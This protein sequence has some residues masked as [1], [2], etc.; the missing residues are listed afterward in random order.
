MDTLK[1]QIP[2][3]SHRKKHIIEN[4]LFMSEL[5][6]KNCFIVKQ[7]FNV[8][9]EY[10]LNLYEGDSLTLNT[11]D[12]F[13]FDH[14]TITIGN[15]PYN[16]E[17][18]SAGSAKPLYNKFIERFID[19]CDILCFVIPSRWFSCGKGLDTFREGMLKRTDIVY[20]KHF[21]DASK[22]FGNSVDIKGGVNYF[23]KDNFYS[24]ECNFNGTMTKLNKY[25]VFVD[26]MYHSIIDKIIPFES[27]TTLFLGNYFGIITNDKKLKNT[28]TKDTVKCYVSQ[29]KG[30]ERY[31]SN[32]D[33]KKEYNFWKVITTE[34]AH[35]HKSGFGNTFI[36]NCNEIYSGSYIS[37]RVSSESEAGSL[38]SYLKCR[39]PNFMLSLRKN[40]QHINTSTCTWIPLVPLDK[41]WTDTEVYSY[42]KLSDADIQLINNTDIIG[43]RTD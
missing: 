29:Q 39:L 6:K 36:G 15:P 42:L 30:F 25:D 27:I 26:G 35:K 9:N 7:I 3:D 5:N 11:L 20:M 1:V 14:N 38:L 37:F 2:D 19:K 18:K 12:V 16:E 43:Y 41:I 13:G 24:G 32:S 33:I 21:D 23:L 4:M 17:L 10:H 8:N 28:K 22:I 34:A 31:I 40:S